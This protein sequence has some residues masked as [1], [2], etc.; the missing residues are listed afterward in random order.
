MKKKNL[1]FILLVLIGLTLVGCNFGAR[2]EESEVTDADLI[3][4]QVAETVQAQLAL[5][6]QSE[7]A[8]TL[9]FTME[10]AEST[11]TPTQT[12]TP[13]ETPTIIN[14]E[15]NAGG[16]TGG[17]TTPCDEA[18]FVADVT[19]P[20]GTQFFPGTQFTKTWKLSNAGTCTWNT[21]YQV[22]F[23]SG[24]QMDAEAAYPLTFNVAPGQVV[25]ISID[26]TAPAEDGEYT[27]NWVFKNANGQAF[28]LGKNVAPFYV[29]IEASSTLASLTPSHTP[30]VTGTPPTATPSPTPGS[31]ETP[32]PGPT[33][34]PTPTPTDTPPPA[35]TDTPTPT[36]TPTETPT[37]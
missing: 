29:Q 34:T 22:V 30:T 3:F 23:S 24:S 18:A 37:P 5:T 10:V 19:I 8:P 31:T 15:G 13:T 36:E 9:T 28:G 35:D 21:A 16:N 32:T 4:T 14:N 25:D 11:A 20:D 17:A 6:Q 12:P 1:K 2:G 27:G 7:A 26:M 33:D